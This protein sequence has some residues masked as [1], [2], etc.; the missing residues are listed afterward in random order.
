LKEIPLKQI[1]HQIVEP[2]ESEKG[3]ISQNLTVKIY[4]YVLPNRLKDAAKLAGADKQSP[5]T[6]L[7]AADHPQFYRIMFEALFV[8]LT[9]LHYL[10]NFANEK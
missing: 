3:V 9:I 5:T 4:R 10:T 8:D 1:P 7:N 6:H 2:F